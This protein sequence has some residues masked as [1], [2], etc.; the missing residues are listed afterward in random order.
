M[1]EGE[2]GIAARHHQRPSGGKQAL[3]LLGRKADSVE[4]RQER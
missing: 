4:G 3:T 1:Q 2:A